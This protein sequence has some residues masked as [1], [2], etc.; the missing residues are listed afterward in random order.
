[1]PNGF[2]YRFP[3]L[4]VLMASLHRSPAVD[5]FNVGVVVFVIYISPI[6]PINKDRITS[7]RFKGAYGRIYSTWNEILG[8]FEKIFTLVDLHSRYYSI[9]NAPLANLKMGT[10]LLE[11][12]L[13]KSNPKVSFP[14][15]N[16]D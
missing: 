9:S 2:D 1:A 4:L 6:C 8:S 13:V 3:Y 7:Y 14:L 10:N 11:L 16:A 15:W 12:L 5:Q